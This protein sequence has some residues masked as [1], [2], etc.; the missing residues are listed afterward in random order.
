[1]VMKEQ[2]DSKFAVIQYGQEQLDSKFVA[3]Q[4][5]MKDDQQLLLFA[6]SEKRVARLETLS[7]AAAG[8]GVVGIVHAPNVKVLSDDGSTSW[9]AY[10][11]QFQTVTT[12][13]TVLEALPSSGSEYKELLNVFHAKLRDR[14]QRPGEGLQ[15]WTLEIERLVRKAY[16]SADARMVESITVQTFVA[17]MLNHQ[18]SLKEAL[19]HGLEVEAV[20]QDI[21]P[22][23]KLHKVSKDVKEVK[24]YHLQ[25]VVP[26]AKVPDVPGKVHDGVSGGHLIV[27]R[28]LIKIRERFY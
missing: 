5:Q 20:R 27:I 21:R 24:E 3:I 19:S 25:I 14:V 12:A 15:Q 4:K 1:M 23:R 10:Y 26:R 2:L 9:I 28:T 7:V 16:L 11:Q 8:S 13:L 18:T 17:A 6:V 22:T